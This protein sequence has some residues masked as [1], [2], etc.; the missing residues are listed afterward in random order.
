MHTELRVNCIGPKKMPSQIRRLPY[1][2]AIEVQ[3]SIGTP[4][5]YLF[6][7]KSTLLLKEDMAMLVLTRK[8][9][10]SIVIDGGITVTI[11]SID[12]G[13]VRIGITA[14]PEVRVDREE[15]FQRR[16]EFID[17]VDAAEPASA[18]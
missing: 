10:E 8:V 14:P 15:V 11:V 13:K 4:N 17:I 18:F 6:R 5:A 1:L 7:D 2:L 12:R 9:N 3:A 16:Q